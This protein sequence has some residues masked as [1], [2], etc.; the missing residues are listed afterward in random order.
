MAMNGFDTVAC[1][2]ED[3]RMTYSEK[4]LARITDTGSNL[5]VGI[6]PRPDLIDGDLEATLGRFV[7]ETTPYAACFKPNIAYFEALGS[8]GYAMLER[9]IEQIDG[10]V[11]ILLDAKRGDIGATQEY[12][13]K[14]YFDRMDVDAVTL[15]PFMGFDAIEPFLKYE[16][17]AVY[18]LAVTSNAGSA[19]IE[20]Q[21]T[22]SGRYVFELVQDMAT[23]GREAGLPGEVGLGGGV[24]ECQRSSDLPRR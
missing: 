13:A 19:D 5:C 11:P 23:R 15:N 4:L 6:D 12:Y 21:K 18:L 3:G 16:N 1:R 2:I 22:E 14:A 8:G 10:A 20:L 7:E 9:L 17:R 24:D